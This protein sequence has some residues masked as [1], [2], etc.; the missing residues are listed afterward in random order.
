ME[1]QWSKKGAQTG[2]KDQKPDP[3]ISVDRCSNSR[4]YRRMF[5]GRQSDR[6][7]GSG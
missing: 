3:G 1:Q 4:D 6:S 5:S 2:E 7:E